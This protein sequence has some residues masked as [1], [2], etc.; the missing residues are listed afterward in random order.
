MGRV[1][2]VQETS[3]EMVAISEDGVVQSICEQPVFGVIKDIAILPWNKNFRAQ[4]SRV[5]HDLYS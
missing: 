2:I 4:N 1:R 5:F 3:I